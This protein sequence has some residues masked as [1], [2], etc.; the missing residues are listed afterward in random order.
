V[1][2]SLNGQLNKYGIS[3][4]TDSNG[5]LQFSGSNAFTLASDQA[6][7]GAGQLLTSTGAAGTG[8]ATNNS[9]YTVDS[10][11]WVVTTAAETMKI[12]TSAGAATV[13]IP[14]GESLAA[15]ISDINAQTASL[16]VFAVLNA[17]GTGVSFQGSNS[18]SVQDTAAG[19]AEGVFGAAST[20]VTSTAPTA[21]STSNAD[22]AITALDAA[23]QTL[24]LV[25]GRVGAGENLLQYAINLA[26]SQISSFSA[27]ESQIRDA[28]VAAQA[29][30]L[31][32]SQVLTQTSV[33]ALAQANAQPQAVL[34]LLQ[35]S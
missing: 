34:K 10:G 19:G 33:A 6:T 13:N 17:A 16:G 12:Q 4:D 26:Q 8:T 11:T 28:D 23:V 30:N 35:G 24:G 14:T 1:L 22:S 29:A 32:K 27:A 18:F 7:G 3:A 20:Y 2:S 21:G 5:Q 25:Q 31:T 9:N 15:T